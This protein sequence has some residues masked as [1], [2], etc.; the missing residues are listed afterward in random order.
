MGERKRMVGVERE[1]GLECLLR[2]L[3][4][5]VH[6]HDTC[7]VMDGEFGASVTT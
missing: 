4:W 5:I 6:D 2:E 7:H 3:G 1:R